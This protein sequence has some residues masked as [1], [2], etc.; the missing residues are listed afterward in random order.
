MGTPNKGS[1]FWI[2]PA[3]WEC[4]LKVLKT[5]ELPGERLR[6]NAQLGQGVHVPLPVKLHLESWEGANTY[7]SYSLQILVVLF[8][9]TA[10][11]V[12][13][14]KYTIPPKPF[15]VIQAPARSQR[16]ESLVKSGNP[17]LF[18]PLC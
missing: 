2:L 15:Q 11:T 17:Q 6:P 13:S 5:Q 1:T 12:Y 4:T 3:V 10:G 16:K 14:V 9:R 8:L 18:T 7:R